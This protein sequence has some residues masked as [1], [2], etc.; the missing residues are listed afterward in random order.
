M[1]VGDLI[2]ITGVIYTGRDA[3]LPQLVRELDEGH[4]RGPDLN[5]GVIL[6][7]GVSVAG[8]GP[9][10]SNKKEIEGSI[11]PLSRLGVRLHI[12]KGK[13]SSATVEELARFGSVFAI[14]PPT[15]AL[16]RDRVTAQR[17]V[18][19]PNEGMEAMYE[20]TVERFP[21]V[22]AVARRKTVWDGSGG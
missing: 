5:G 20:L 6:H 9:T 14:T 3:I 22:V 15:T 4:W 2:E 7:T 8:V 19:F 11:G 17:V 10:T 1:E 18:A 21:A 16:F 13:L 12:G